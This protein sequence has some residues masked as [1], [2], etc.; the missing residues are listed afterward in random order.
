[1]KNFNS[2]FEDL[3]STKINYKTSLEN[4]LLYRNKENPSIRTYDLDS[5]P[6]KVTFLSELDL[7]KDKFSGFGSH[8]DKWSERHFKTPEV[9]KIQ[10]QKD[11]NTCFREKRQNALNSFIKNLKSDLYTILGL[12]AGAIKK[13]IIHAYRKLSKIYHPDKNPD[14]NSKFYLI[15]N[16][17]KILSNDEFRNLYDEFGLEYV[18]NYINMLSSYPS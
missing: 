16:A 3:A 12:E 2:I 13:D 15:N 9:D 8:N 17:Y 10:N 18:T 6:L 4:S 1:M 14:D 7:E 5:T 11:L